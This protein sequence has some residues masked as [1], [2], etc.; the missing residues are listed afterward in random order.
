VAHRETEKFRNLFDSNVQKRLRENVRKHHL[1]TKRFFGILGGTFQTA[2]HSST[3]SQR[4]VSSHTLT[5]Q[6]SSSSSS[7]G[8]GGTPTTLSQTKKL[9]CPELV[10]LH[11]FIP[12]KNDLYR[13]HIFQFLVWLY[14]LPYWLYTFFWLFLRTLAFVKA[15]NSVSLFLM[16]QAADHVAH[17]VFYHDKISFAETLE[18]YRYRLG[19]CLDN[20]RVEASSGTIASAQ[21]DFSAWV[22][23]TPM[24]FPFF[25][26]RVLGRGTS[27]L[28]VE[29]ERRADDHVILHWIYYFRLNRDCDIDQAHFT[30]HYAPWMC[31]RVSLDVRISNNLPSLGIS[32]EHTAVPS[33]RLK[34]S[35]PNQLINSREKYSKD[36]DMRKHRKNV[37]DTFCCGE[38]FIHDLQ[39]PSTFK[40]A[41][42]PVENRIDTPLET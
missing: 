12:V 2:I 28:E 39:Y 5:L 40:V 20:I 26:W 30:G 32:I 37:I 23:D 11:G 24:Y 16:Y 36:Y 19:V 35:K 29:I 25:G 22:G 7:S 9:V 33:L 3:L 27:K 14:E 15:S 41:D 10:F 34:I 18:S 8:T 13:Y 31:C 4:G 1:N 17:K 6:Y 38:K 21:A 42:F